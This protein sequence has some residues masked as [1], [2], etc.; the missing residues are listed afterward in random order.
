MIQIRVFVTVWSTTML[1]SHKL[2]RCKNLSKT[3]LS[4]TV[5]IKAIKL[6]SDINGWSSA[7]LFFK[8][9]L[10]M[11]V[12]LNIRKGN[13]MS[14]CVVNVRRV[15]RVIFTN[16]SSYNWEE[17]DEKLPLI[18]LSHVWFPL[19]ARWSQPVM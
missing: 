11:P 16:Y 8:S 3:P 6:K 2:L 18:P 7:T 17:P 19:W 12:Q 4:F 14:Q 13:Q 9:I 15:Q 1:T 10:Q 5:N